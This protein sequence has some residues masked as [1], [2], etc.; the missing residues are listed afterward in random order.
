[1][2][3]ILS[4][5]PTTVQEQSKCTFLRAFGINQSG[6]LKELH[7]STNDFP[8]DLNERFLEKTQVIKA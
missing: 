3:S 7:I 5:I 1:M 4:G 2:I 6:T 8:T